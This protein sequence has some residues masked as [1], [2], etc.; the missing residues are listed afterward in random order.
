MHNLCTYVYTC[1][2]MPVRPEIPSYYFLND[3]FI[4]TIM[5]L[6]QDSMYLETHLLQLE[7][8]NNLYLIKLY[9]NSFS[10]YILKV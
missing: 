4:E 3:Y 7:V 2:C 8:L 10:L 6:F 5:M 1:M 9:F